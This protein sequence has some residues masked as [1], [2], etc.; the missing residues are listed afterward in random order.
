M[1]KFRIQLQGELME[2][3][4]KDNDIPDILIK[5]E[6]HN[7]IF[8]FIKTGVVTFD[9]VTQLVSSYKNYIHEYKIATIKE[10]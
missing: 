6:P 8:Y 1:R 3:E 9:Q 10:I 7:G 2:R 4:I 5:K